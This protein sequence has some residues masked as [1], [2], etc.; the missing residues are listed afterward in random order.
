MP[1]VVLLD[2]DM[3]LMNGFEALPLLHERHPE[4]A[5]IVLSTTWSAEIEREALALGATACLEKPRNVFDLPDVLRG[6]LGEP[7]PV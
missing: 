5:V 3:P 7:E 1:D 2:I 4:T 6:A